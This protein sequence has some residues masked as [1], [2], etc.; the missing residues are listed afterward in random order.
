M[1]ETS[2]LKVNVGLSRKIGEAGYSSRGGAV[3]LEAELESDLTSAPDKLQ[4][5]IRH[6]FGL[7]RTALAAELQVPATAPPTMVSVTQTAATP[8]PSRQRQPIQPTVASVAPAAPNGIRHATA[9]QVKAIQSLARRKAV[10][11]DDL[12]HHRFGIF[13]VAELT[14]TQASRLI[15]ELNAMPDPILAEEEDVETIPF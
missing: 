4:D 6:L 13:R 3:H 11:A 5:R 8:P 9:A 1:K 2:M 12:S 14:V 15:D 10:V 7:A